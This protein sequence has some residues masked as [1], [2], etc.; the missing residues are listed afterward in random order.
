MTNPIFSLIVILLSVGA[1]FFYVRPEYTLVQKRGADLVA[2]T[3][4]A[5]KSSSIEGLISK[6]EKDLDSVD[7][8]DLARFAVFLPETV[9]PIRFANNI[10]HVGVVNGIVIEDLKVEEQST[11]ASTNTAEASSA[12]GAAR[13]VTNTF[14]LG[15]KVDQAQGATL[16]GS[17]A[18]V[19]KERNYAT[20][21]ATFSFTTTY[22]KFSLILNDLEKSLGLINVTDLSFAPAEDVATTQKSK[23][24]EP[25]AYRFLVTIE[26]YSLK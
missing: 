7:P 19:A 16:G 14:S 17:V 20:T 9:D 2:L 10:Q 24:P 1:A 21:K 23:K 4:T 12:G 3:E 6:T 13:G 5:K 11:G 22:E 25:P 26:T 18:G 15:S 8:A